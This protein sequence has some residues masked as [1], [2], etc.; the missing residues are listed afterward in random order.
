MTRDTQA[1][2][3]QSQE[4]NQRIIDA[5]KLYL[6]LGLSVI[7]VPR[8]EKRPVVKW[9]A[10]ASARPCQADW[11]AWWRET[12][13]CNLAVV[14]SSSAA[15]DGRQLVCVDTDTPKAESWVCAQRPLPPTATVTTAKGKHR[16]Y[17]APIGLTHY[18]GAE[19]MPEVRAGVHYSVLPPS[20]HPTGILYEWD[21]C[22]SIEEAGIADLPHWGVALMGELEPVTDADAQ[23]VEQKPVPEG[24]RNET[25]FRQCAKWRAASVPDEQ[26]RASAHAFNREHCAPPLEAREV[27][28]VV[29]SVLRYAP[30]TSVRVQETDRRQ[31]QQQPAPAQEDC[32]YSASLAASAEAAVNAVPAPQRIIGARPVSEDAMDVLESVDARRYLA[33]KV[34][35]MRTGWP[36]IDW[37]FLGFKH[38]GLMW[39]GGASGSSKS[40]LMRHIVFATAEA[41]AA[42]CLGSRVLV[43]AL[44]GGKEQFLR[45]FAGYKYGLSIRLFQPGGAARITEDEQDRMLAAYSEYPSLPLDI[46]T[47]MRNA[48]QIMFDIE[49]RAAEGAI[50]GVILDNVQLLEFHGRNQWAENQRVALKA[51]DLADRFEFPFIALSQ[52]NKTRDGIKP[53]MGPEWYNNATATFMIERGESGDSDAQ[54]QLSNKTTL[55][56]LKARYLTSCC[57][58]ITLIGERE[59]GRLYEETPDTHQQQQQAAQGGASAEWPGND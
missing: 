6:R 27:D 54:R 14:Y 30:G 43:Y 32:G 23:R 49:R 22:L 44:E 19:S 8:G 28:T 34:H 25:L 4:R 53:R 31:K 11:N 16:Y 55:M 5:I 15:P 21:D 12:P 33:Y 57:H 48:D 59:T 35:G 50:E 20:V 37:H 24:R 47:D 51:L 36:T 40:T 13:G 9:G 56:N 26:L 10:F 29:K 7:P 38:Q 39:V 17:Y 1:D 42:E 41:I 3:I 18:Q 46:C 58:P 45:Y 2:S 52:V